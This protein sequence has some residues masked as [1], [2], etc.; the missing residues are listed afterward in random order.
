MLPLQA[1]GL[2]I[3]VGLAGGAALLLAAG[4]CAR[5]GRVL[6]RILAAALLAVGA[7]ALLV[8]LLRQVP[9]PL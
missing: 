3:L 1:N 7:L 6:C 4:R 8:R 9:V 2:C 5:P